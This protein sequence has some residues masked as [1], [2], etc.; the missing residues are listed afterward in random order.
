MPQNLIV[1]GFGGT[2]R[3]SEVLSE[4]QKLEDSWAIDLDDAVAAAGGTRR[5]HSP[6]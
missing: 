3:A 1:V 5:A 4:R 2:R 6:R